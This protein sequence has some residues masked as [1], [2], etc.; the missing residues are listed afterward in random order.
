MRKIDQAI[1]RDP[2]EVTRNDIEDKAT[3]FTNLYIKAMRWLALP[4]SESVDINKFAPG[5]REEFR[6]SSIYMQEFVALSK[7][8]QKMFN[9]VPQIISFGKRRSISK[10]I[11][12]S[13]KQYDR[14]VKLDQQI[15][16]QR[17][18]IHQKN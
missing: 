10:I 1:T 18:K 3:V 6:S 15:A 5:V 13:Q 8:V 7:C 17:R 2:K 14:I 12:K 4:S 16:E 11:M 9:A